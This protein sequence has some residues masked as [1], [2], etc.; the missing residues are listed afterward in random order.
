MTTVCIVGAGM[1]DSVL[2]CEL[3]KHDCSQIILIDTDSISQPF[4]RDR[5]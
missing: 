4:S 2:A 3:L 5:A 1:S